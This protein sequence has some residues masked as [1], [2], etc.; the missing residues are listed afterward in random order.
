M[1]GG[2]QN[3]VQSK[4]QVSCP[5]TPFSPQPGLAAEAVDIGVKTCVARAE[6]F[7]WVLGPFRLSQQTGAP[8]LQDKDWALGGPCGDRGAWRPAAGRALWTGRS[9]VP[10][11]GPY[12][13]ACGRA[14]RPPRDPPSPP[15]ERGSG[16]ARGRLCVLRPAV[17]HG[18]G[19]TQGRGGAG[20][21]LPRRSRYSCCAMGF[22]SLSG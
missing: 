18:R 15:R 17:R 13:V 8:R 22:F 9:H 7:S 12:T 2:A 6:D 1:P 16:G 20:P 4:V 10:W 21:A 19:A 5:S 14:L 11:R 3:R